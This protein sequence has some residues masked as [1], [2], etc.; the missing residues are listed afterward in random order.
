MKRLLVAAVASLGLVTASLPAA[1]A[2]IAPSRMLPVK[3]PAYMPFNWGGWYAGLNLGGGFSDVSGVI[4]GGQIGYNW[5]F[6][7]WVFG[8]ETDIQFSGQ[9]SDSVFTGGGATFVDKQELDWFG[10]FRGRLGYS[11]WDR[12]LPYVTGGLAYGGRKASG[13][14]TGT[15]GGAY[16]A[17]D[18]VVGWALGFGV[19][20]AITPAWT[21]RLEYLHVS[22]D[23]FSP[24][25]VLA[26]GTA[27]VNYGRLDNDI[28]R[29]ALNYRF[30]SLGYPY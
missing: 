15:L 29:G 20:Y 10:T 13:A 28:V 3:A 17:D 8:L 21:A 18:T 25:Y 19:D 5:Q 7:Q 30:M 1:A 14:V 23:S 4:F 2:D 12:W 16:S 26:G 27:T 6:G 11:V 9:D 24:T 22:L